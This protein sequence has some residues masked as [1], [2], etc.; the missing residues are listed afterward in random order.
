MVYVSYQIEK[1]KSTIINNLF[2]TYFMKMCNINIF[3]VNIA[4]KNSPNN[5]NIIY[6]I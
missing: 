5:F 1:Y 2:F 3:S 4:Y 6:I